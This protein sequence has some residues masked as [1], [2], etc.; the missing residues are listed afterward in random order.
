[1]SKRKPYE[2]RN[3]IM[4]LLRDKPLS[5]TQIQNKLSTNYDSVKNNCEELQNYEL[6]KINIVEKH[7]ENGKPSFDV[8]LTP[9]GRQIIKQIKS[10]KE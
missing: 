10:K 5:Y 8:E 7:P 9:R 2:V 4:L 6:V 3:E 1:M